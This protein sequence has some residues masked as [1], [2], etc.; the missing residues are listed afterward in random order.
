MPWTWSHFFTFI[1]SI[2][3]FVLLAIYIG[4]KLKD[5]SEN[6]RLIPIHI[7]TV[8]IIVLEIIKQVRS[9]VLGYDLDN[10]PL[11]FCSMFLYLYPAVSLYQGKYKY[12]V[13]F[14]TAISGV[15]VLGVMAIMPNIIYSDSAIRKFFTDF[16]YFH[17]VIYHNLFY[18][19]TCF[20]FTLGLID[21]KIKNKFW[22]VFCFSL[23]YCILVIPIALGLDVN[24]NNFC[25]NN[26]PIIE[27]LRLLQ[28]EKLGFGGQIIY[29]LEATMTTV[30]FSVAMYFLIMFVI[31]KIN[32]WKSK[33]RDK[34]K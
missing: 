2:I 16:D 31:H 23:G 11:Y 8:S 12:H 34:E 27:K 32:V 5:K 9:I 13:R 4:G 20:M 7:I 14:L 29:E 30:G 24:F 1:P 25:R 17:T 6:I 21:F 22:T 19:G 28:V 18:L 10:L 15:T 33:T 26:A 3:I